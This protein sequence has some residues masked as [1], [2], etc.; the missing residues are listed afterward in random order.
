MLRIT[1]QYN[2]WYKQRFPFQWMDARWR[3]NKMARKNIGPFIHLTNKLNH[4]ISVVC[5]LSTGKRFSV[6][7]LLFVKSCICKLDKQAESLKG[8]LREPNSKAYKMKHHRFRTYNKTMQ[9]TENAMINRIF[10]IEIA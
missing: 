9:I 3:G 2:W 10:R 5:W 8:Q 7:S 1:W 6:M 4:Y